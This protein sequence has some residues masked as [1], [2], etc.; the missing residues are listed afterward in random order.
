M[1]NWK[2]LLI[3]LL[4]DYN[5]N[6]FS[7]WPPLLVYIHKV[8]RNSMEMLP[9]VC[10]LCKKWKASCLQQCITIPSYKRVKEQKHIFVVL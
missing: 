2:F 10:V 8:L 7:K 3:S 4:N 1:H 9:E 5:K 6:I